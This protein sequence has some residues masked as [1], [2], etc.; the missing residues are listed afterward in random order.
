M[1]HAVRN[2]SKNVAI[3]TPEYS[4]HPREDDLTG[5]EEMGGGFMLTTLP[6]SPRMS[7]EKPVIRPQ[8][9]QARESKS[10]RYFLSIKAR[11]RFLG[12]L[13]G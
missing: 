4:K 10:S 6:D 2:T 7:S 13:F 1:T 8:G 12:M 3:T 5:V 9:D 11:M